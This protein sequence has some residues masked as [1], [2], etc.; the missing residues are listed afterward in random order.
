MCTHAPSNTSEY[1]AYLESP[2]GILVFGY[3]YIIEKYL[4]IPLLTLHVC[5]LPKTRSLIFYC[6]LILMETY[7]ISIENPGEKI[8]YI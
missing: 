8:H 3:E 1:L 6:S 5:S 4:F 2:S 7:G